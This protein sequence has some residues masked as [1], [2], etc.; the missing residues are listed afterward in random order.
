MTINTKKAVR[1]VS[2]ILCFIIIILLCA[3][4]GRLASKKEAVSDGGVR[5]YFVDSVSSLLKPEARDLRADTNSALLSLVLTELKAGPKLE[6]FKPAIPNEVEF[7]SVNIDRGVITVD[8]SRQYNS[9]KA[10]EELVCRGAIVKTLTELGFVEF[11]KIT[12]EGRELEKP[13]GKPVGRMGAADIVT[14]G[15]I[16]PEL[17]NYETVTLYFANVSASGLVEERRKIAVN[18]NEPIERYIVEQLIA[19]PLAEGSYA[20]VPAEAKLRSIRTETSDGIC[21]VDFSSDFVTRHTGGSA[22]ETLTIYS[23]VNSLTELESI[24][25]VQFLIEGEKQEE[26]K[27]HVEFGKP[28]EPNRDLIED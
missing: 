22:S 2:I 12:V 3:I 1:A 15:I 6:G 17:T 19:G 21:Y 24:K 4:I 28:F 20:T 18:P 11:V 25:K 23:I 10:S 5:L 14:D 13:N 27:G 7:N 8:V 26:F 16:S 9:L